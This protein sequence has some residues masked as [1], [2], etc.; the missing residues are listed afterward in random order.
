M[1]KKIFVVVL[2]YLVDIE[3]INAARSSHLD[4]LK[5]YYD[6]GVF[7]CSGRQNS[8]NGGIILA[9]CESRE[10]LLNILHQ[11]PFY[12]KGLAELQIFDFIPHNVSK[13][14]GQFMETL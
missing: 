1:E 10:T 12:I 5:Q 8:G 9:H 2:R 4:F 3:L 13:N 6:N 7:F 14:F 11:D